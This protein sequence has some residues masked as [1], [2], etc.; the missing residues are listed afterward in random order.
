MDHGSARGIPVADGKKRGRLTERHADFSV[1]KD[2]SLTQ[3]YLE[4]LRRWTTVRDI[5]AG[6]S[7]PRDRAMKRP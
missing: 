3:R 4:Q 6:N 1:L 5:S 2:M 7:E